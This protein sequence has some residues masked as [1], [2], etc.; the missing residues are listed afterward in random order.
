MPEAFFDSILTKHTASNADI[1]KG[2]VVDEVSRVDDAGVEDIDA[3]DIL[4]SARRFECCRGSWQW[5]A[6]PS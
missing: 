6:F 2:L 5:F 3:I 4:P 1:L